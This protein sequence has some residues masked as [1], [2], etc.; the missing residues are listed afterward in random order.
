MATEKKF[1]TGLVQIPVK[2]G[3]R[4]EN[5]ETVR[6]WMKEFYKPAEMTTALVL[7]ELWDVGYALDS[8]P[9]LADPNAA[10]AV[11]FLGALAKQ[12]NCWF[13]GGSV[14]TEDGG[15]HYNRTLVINPKGELVTHYDKV[16]LVPFIT[17]EDGVFEMGD[18]PCIFDMDGIKAGTVIC[19]DIRFPEWI[20]IYALRGVEVFFIC[21]QWTRNRMDLYRTMIR[22]HAI[23]NMFYTVAVN[24][25]DLS[26]DIDFG[27]E[28]F[29][30]SPT[31][32]V[33]AECSGTYDG[34]FADIDATSIDE[35]RKFLKVIEKRRPTLYRELVS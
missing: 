16:H 5:Q 10:Q 3:D 21:S 25:C 27:G 4:K 7:P 35:N 2:L 14:M 29:V 18:K 8:V 22:A 32:E 34:K 23:E 28:S 13:A 17:V 31:G 20:R 26:G 15:K 33:I 12:H 24:N 9:R 6:R 30:S 19:Y 11:E 1:R